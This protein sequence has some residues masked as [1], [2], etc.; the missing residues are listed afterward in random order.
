MI[1]A[2]FEKT[3]FIFSRIYSIVKRNSTRKNEEFFLRIKV[4]SN[5]SPI[6]RFHQCCL[7]L[8]F[9]CKTFSRI[10]A[11]RKPY[12][13]V[14]PSKSSIFDLSLISIVFNINP[15]IL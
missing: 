10:T 3:I 7:H 14:E 2:L 13:S 4:S 5:V 8:E 1:E 11:Y 12:V 15:S 9:N 6:T